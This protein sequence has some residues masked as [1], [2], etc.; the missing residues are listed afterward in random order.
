RVAPVGIGLECNRTL[1]RVND[2]VCA[3]SGYSREELVGQ[4]A[5]MFYPTEDDYERVR[6]KNRPQIHEMG[7]ATVE[8]RWKRKGGQIIDV[9]LSTTVLD[10]ADFSK[11]VTF[12]ALDITRREC[13]ERVRGEIQVSR[14]TIAQYD[15]H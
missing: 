9:L 14:R 6:Q 10:R 7:A 13:A 1:A 12:T 2:Q 5:A 11:G 8:T 15:F 4:R 3:M